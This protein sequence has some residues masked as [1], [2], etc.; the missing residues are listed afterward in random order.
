[1]TAADLT[2]RSMLAALGAGGLGFALFGPKSAG[3]PPAGRVVIDYWEKWTGQEALAMQRIIDRFNASQDRI[4]VRFFSMSAIEQKAM[5]SIGRI[6]NTDNLD[7][8]K[9]G[10]TLS[11]RGHIVAEDTR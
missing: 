11:D 4:W 1:M 6:P 5:I 7:L 3:D 10:V 8:D 2:R 9:A